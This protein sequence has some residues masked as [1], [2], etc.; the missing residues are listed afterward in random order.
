MT[1]PHAHIIDQQ[2]AAHHDA[3]RH[4]DGWEPEQPTQADIEHNPPVPTP[5][6]PYDTECPCLVCAMRKAYT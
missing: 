3:A 1:H 5:P 2:R 4:W 6:H